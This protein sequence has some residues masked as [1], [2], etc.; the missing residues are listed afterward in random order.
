MIFLSSKS[1]QKTIW[2]KWVAF[3]SPVMIGRP[4]LILKEVKYSHENIVK[5]NDSPHAGK[6]SDQRPFLEEAG[7]KG[8]LLCHSSEGT[9]STEATGWFTDRA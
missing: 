1:F 7:F 3:S 8:H 2:A 9:P 4:G 6:F 5:T